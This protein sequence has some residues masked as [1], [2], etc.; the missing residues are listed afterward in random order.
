L[1][2][3][4]IVEQSVNESA[5]QLERA[6]HLDQRQANFP[7]KRERPVSLGMLAT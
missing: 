7:A 4:Y 5:K 6:E 2:F 1:Q 3:R